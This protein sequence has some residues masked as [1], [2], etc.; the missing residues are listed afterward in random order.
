M[1]GNWQR[2]SFCVEPEHSFNSKYGKMCARLWHAHYSLPSELLISRFGAAIKYSLFA[3]AQVVRCVVL[4]RGCPARRALLPH[5]QNSITSLVTHTQPL[6]CTICA[7]PAQNQCYYFLP[8]ALSGSKQQRA[9]ARPGGNK[10]WLNGYFCCR[11]ICI[12]EKNEY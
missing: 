7:F 4:T 5:P 12:D 2:Q 8:R 9:R 1:C 3:S 11:R 6:N 10:L